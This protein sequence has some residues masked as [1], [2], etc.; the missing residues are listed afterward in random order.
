MRSP[1]GL[2]EFLWRLAVGL[3]TVYV[4]LRLLPVAGVRVTDLV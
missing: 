2:A 3:L 1:A 4:S